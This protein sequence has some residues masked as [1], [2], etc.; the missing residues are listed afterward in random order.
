[1]LTNTVEPWSAAAYS[2]CP[3]CHPAAKKQ[4]AGRLLPD[5]LEAAIQDVADH[6]NADGDF[7]SNE[8]ERATENLRMK[9]RAYG[10][11]C[12]AQLPNQGGVGRK[13]VGGEDASGDANGEVDALLAELT[14]HRNLM[15][16]GRG[17]G[18]GDRC[19]GDDPSYWCVQ[20]NNLR[21]MTELARALSRGVPEGK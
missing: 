12:R 4:D 18:M 1:M 16:C 20:C 2:P 11:Q 10:E 8:T 21:R 6:A 7:V 9:I 3:D 19:I 15:P 13:S 5:E 14:R 17:Y